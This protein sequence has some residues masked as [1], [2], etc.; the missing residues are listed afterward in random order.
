MQTVQTQ[1]FSPVYK[2]DTLK[3]L[4]ATKASKATYPDQIPARIIRDITDEIAAP[5]TLSVLRITN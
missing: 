2:H 1:T 4:L 5:L 3:I